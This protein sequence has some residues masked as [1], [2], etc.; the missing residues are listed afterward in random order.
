MIQ[1]S[2]THQLHTAWERLALLSLLLSTAC[3]VD[4]LEDPIFQRESAL[5]AGAPL[6]D[7][8]DDGYYTAVVGISLGVAQRSSVTKQCSR[9]RIACVPRKRPRPAAAHGARSLFQT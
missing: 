9:P 1:S 8:Q 5:T 4:A 2:Q 7:L 6:K 3:A